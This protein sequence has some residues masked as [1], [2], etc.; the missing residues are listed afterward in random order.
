MYPY[1]RFNHTLTESVSNNQ[2]PELN[3]IKKIEVI[4]VRFKTNKNYH[5]SQ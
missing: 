3:A 1:E 5:D 2:N 4:T